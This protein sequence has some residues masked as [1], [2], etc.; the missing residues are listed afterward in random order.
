MSQAIWKREAA[1][2]LGLLAFG[3]L[4]PPFAIYLVGRQLIGEYSAAGVMG[5]AERLWGDLLAFEL[6]A[7][8]L[9]LC[10]YVLVQLARFVYR[11][12][13]PREPVIPVT[14]SRGNTH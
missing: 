5:L 7:W 3:I 4:V 1:I 14:D 11:L 12:W 6:G 13:R 10:P 2:A 8:V 9:A